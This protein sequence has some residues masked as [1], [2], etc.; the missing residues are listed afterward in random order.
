MVHSVVVT[1]V[2]RTYYH[3]IMDWSINASKMDKLSFVSLSSQ[4]I[5]NNRHP[6]YKTHL[7]FV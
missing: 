6:K 4:T 2:L 3:G 1:C 7:F 5:S